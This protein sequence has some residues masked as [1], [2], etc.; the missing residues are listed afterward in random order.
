MK[1]LLSW[2]IPILLFTAGLAAAVGSGVV[3][4]GAVKNWCTAGGVALSLLTGLLLGRREPVTSFLSARP[5]LWFLFFFNTAAAFAAASLVSGARGVGTAVGMGVVAAGAY[6]GLQRDRT[7]RRAV[8][9]RR[10]A[11]GQSQ[12][13]IKSVD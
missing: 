1:I 4:D 11:S 5:V 10:H 9:G 13:A 6:L 7:P 3:L 2:I 12:H 8:R